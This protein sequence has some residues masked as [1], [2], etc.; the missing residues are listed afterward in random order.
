[1]R[2]GKLLYSAGDF[3]LEK[4]TSPKHRR[5]KVVNTKHKLHTHLRNEKEARDLI[6]FARHNNIP[7]DAKPDYLYS[8]LRLTTDTKQRERIEH[9]IAVKSEGRQYYINI[10]KGN[11]QTPKNK[12]AAG[13][14]K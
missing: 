7:R 11:A 8:L 1:M 13:K 12:R 10:Q 6:N 3:I 9:L 4:T 5:Y 2:L 14:R